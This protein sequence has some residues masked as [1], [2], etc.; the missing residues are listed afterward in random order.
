MPIERDANESL[1]AFLCRVLL[2]LCKVHGG[3]LRIKEDQIDVDTR[4]LLVQDF[5]PRTGEL[6]FYARSRYAQPIWV[7]PRQ[8]AWTI[9]FE[10]R[11]AQLGIN[12]PARHV[13]PTDEE[14]AERERKLRA[15]VTS[16]PPVP[17]TTTSA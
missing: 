6:V 11:A 13:V 8:S 15:R 14:L 3:E 16:R 9:P 2:A 7:Q 17:P 4:Q 10:E 1:E 5:D 12:Q